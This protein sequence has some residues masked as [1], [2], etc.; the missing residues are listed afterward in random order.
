MK[1]LLQISHAHR[2]SDL[3]SL[4][5]GALSLLGLAAS[6][7][8]FDAPPTIV[9]AENFYG[10]VARQIAPEAKITTS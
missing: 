8:A 2:P 6:L 5:V 7:P 4:L 10:S 9:A 1:N 3:W